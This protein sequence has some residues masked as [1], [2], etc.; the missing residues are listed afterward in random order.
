M[1]ATVIAGLG[2]GLLAVLLVA[3]A[4]ATAIVMRRRGR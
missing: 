2:M 4:V 3:A 1:D